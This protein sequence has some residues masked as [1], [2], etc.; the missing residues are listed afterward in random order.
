MED[1][2]LI[3]DKNVEVHEHELGGLSEVNVKWHKGGMV[4]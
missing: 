2:A 1:G 3:Q 4:Y